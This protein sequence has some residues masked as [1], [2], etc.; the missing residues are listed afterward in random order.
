MIAS[1]SLMNTALKHLT[2]TELFLIDIEDDRYSSEFIDAWKQE[3]LKRD[4]WMFYM[5][6][7]YFPDCYF[8]AKP[9]LVIHSGFSTI[10]VD[11]P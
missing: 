1:K 4:D 9:T 7:C 3:V 10:S 8:F 11:C 5:P 6:D 2:D